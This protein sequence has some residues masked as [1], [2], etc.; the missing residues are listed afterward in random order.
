MRK[1]TS[2]KDLAK[3]IDLTL[4]S[5]TATASDIKKLCE[6]ARRYEV[7]A[8]CVAPTFVPLAKELLKDSPVKICTVV[9]FPLGF[10]ITSVKAYEAREM[11]ALGAQEIDFV[12]N[13]RWVKEKRFE[14]ISGEAQ[15]LRSALPET[16]LKA[17]IECGY[18]DQDEM[19][20]LV[21]TLAEAGIDYVKTSTGFGPRGATLEDVKFLHERAYGRIKVKAAGG[22]R[23]LK[24]ALALI[25]AGAERLGTS[26]GLEILSEFEGQK[27]NTL[28]EVEVYVDG[29]C[30]GNPGPGG[31]AAILKCQGQE[32]IVTGSEPHTTNNRMELLA[33]IKALESLKKP[34]KVVIYTDSRYVKDGITKW[35][36]RWV[37]NNFRTSAGKPVKNQDLWKHLAELTTQH[38]VEWR[39]VEGH[40]G[41]PENERCDR[42][43]RE[44][45]KKEQKS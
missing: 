6:G 34:C 18:L 4:L 17:I 28:P 15:E 21:D 3:F 24:Q 43:A 26:A 37:K 10:Q 45:A 1:I 22:I 44:A 35:L 7:A 30:L 27:S 2:V 9:G 5:P 42:L 36:P 41:H 8:I 20:I 31:F 29:A 23:T 40:A 33:A 39:W 13:L 16:V 25:E 32:K 19:A 14:F 11:A 12:I 38:Q